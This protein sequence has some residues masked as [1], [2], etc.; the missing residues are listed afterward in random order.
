MY[1]EMLQKDRIGIKC[2]S[3]IIA[4]IKYPEHP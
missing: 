3:K 4:N 1:I 2:P